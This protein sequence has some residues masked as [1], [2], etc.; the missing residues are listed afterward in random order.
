LII[1]RGE[2]HS[3]HIEHAAHRWYAPIEIDQPTPS[4][5][6]HAALRYIAA[7]SAGG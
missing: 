4:I 6:R 2:V 3:R 7:A 1:T 5:A